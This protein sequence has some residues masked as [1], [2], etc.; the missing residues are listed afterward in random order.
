MRSMTT[1]AGHAAKA[2]YGYDAPNVVVKLFLIGATLVVLGVLFAKRVFT[3]PTTFIDP[4]TFISAGVF[5]A[6]SGIWMIV[7]SRSLKFRTRDRL[8]K[9][10]AL[11]GDE[12]TLDVGCGRGLLLI[13]SAKRLTTG[14]AMGVDIWQTMDQSGNDPS[15][16]LQNAEREGVSSKIKIV[17]GDARKLPFDNATFDVI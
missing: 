15:V 8:M 17:T 5:L 11:R 12:N 1:S 9:D 3:L 6:V 7:G 2:D 16:T 4:S 10:L 13:G 14:K